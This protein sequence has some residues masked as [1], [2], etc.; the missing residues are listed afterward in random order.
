M[1]RR[2]GRTGRAGCARGAVG[3]GWR[4]EEAAPSRGDDV[5]LAEIARAIADGARAVL[6][7]VVDLEGFL[8]ATEPKPRARATE[9]LAHVAEECAMTLD[10]RAVRTLSAFFASR[11]SDF[12]S[13][14]SA[15]RGAEALVKRAN[16]EAIEATSRALFAE[17]DVQGLRQSDREACVRL[18]IEMLRSAHDGA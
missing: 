2:G 4:R 10:D 12:A 16:A 11:L 1:A 17:C 18:A 7:V 5:A 3:A 14:A 13:T 8:T 6:D 9:I 15:A